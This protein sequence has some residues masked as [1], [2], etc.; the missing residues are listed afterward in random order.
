MHGECALW[1][2]SYWV[3]EGMTEQNVWAYVNSNRGR[4]IVQYATDHHLRSHW[5]WVSS[6][7]RQNRGIIAGSLAFFS[8]WNGLYTH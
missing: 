2:E 4:I 8:A 5:R 3:D 1:V 7:V 6:E